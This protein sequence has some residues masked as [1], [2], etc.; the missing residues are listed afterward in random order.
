MPRSI[1]HRVSPSVAQSWLDGKARPPGPGFTDITANRRA[2]VR[3]QRI[4]TALEIATLLVALS[5]AA[6]AVAEWV[7]MVSV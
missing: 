2:H 7:G 5:L 6:F 4:R 1:T 3:D